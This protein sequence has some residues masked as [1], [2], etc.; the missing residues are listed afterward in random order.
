MPKVAGHVHPQAPLDRK[1]VPAGSL[2]VVEAVFQMLTD[3]STR[4]AIGLNNGIHDG[5]VNLTRNL[6]S[7][8]GHLLAGKA[9]QTMQQTRS[10]E[11]TSE[12]QSLMRI[13][14]AV[15]CLQKNTHNKNNNSN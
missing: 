12:L 9:H 11:H 3:R 1:I 6:L 4:G 7:R 2:S 5:G 8:D 10:E 14:Y 15:F 13:T